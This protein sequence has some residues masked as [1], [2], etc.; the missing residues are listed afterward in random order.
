M[1]CQQHQQKWECAFDAGLPA[2]ADTERHLA[3]CPTCSEF[4]R[5]A[6][7]LRGELQRLELPPPDAAADLALLTALRSMP[8]HTFQQR[9]ALWLTGSPE[10][11]GGWRLG[12]AGA[13]SFAAT[14]AVALIAGNSASGSSP[15]REAHSS[16][17]AARYAAVTTGPERLLDVWLARR[18]P[19]ALPP[20]A[21]APPQ[22]H[23]P[24]I[25]IPEPPRPYR[26]GASALTAD[27]C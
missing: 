22:P 10:W 8:V 12:M 11:R 19:N 20:R 3:E 23:A 9:L 14:L 16:A 4:A 18:V 24:D 7:A 27:E 17:D 15:A 5:A 6:R 21:P 25:E 26:R 1:S 13:A 2:P